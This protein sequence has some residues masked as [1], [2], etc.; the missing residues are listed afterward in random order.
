MIRTLDI[1]NF[2]CFDKF[3]ME[4]LARVNLLVGDNNVGKTALLEA[5]RLYVSQGSPHILQYIS[6]DR[7]E[8][9]RHSSNI[10]GWLLNVN[11]LFGDSNKALCISSDD[12]KLTLNIIEKPLEE[13]I[14]GDVKDIKSAFANIALKIEFP[15]QGKP[16][17]IPL[18]YYDV[19]ANDFNCGIPLNLIRAIR[20]QTEHIIT[21]YVP[22]KSLTIEQVASLFQNLQL[23]DDEDNVLKAVRLVD[24]NIQKI[25]VVTNVM[26]S[27]STISSNLFPSI[28]K[29]DIRAKMLGSEKIFS[30][31]SM[32]AGV[33]RMLSIAVSILHSKNGYLFIDEIDSGLHCTVLEKM[34]KMVIE[35]AKRLNVQVFA[36]THSYDCIEALAYYCMRKENKVTDDDVALHRI[37]RE[38]GKSVYY[39]VERI[40]MAVENRIEVR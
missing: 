39:N 23:T 34:W 2:R 31:G 29:P 35:T 21:F 25:Q 33:W 24:P 5:M 8:I 40:K 16:S 32:G 11:F 30:L 18:S 3:H 17:H 13:M 37:D 19:G 26:D 10:E 4:N 9:I 28:R 22:A 7:D 38:D 12:K 36:T 20:A 14:I 15:N 27:G 1:E 6:I